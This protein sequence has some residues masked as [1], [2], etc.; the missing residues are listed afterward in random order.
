MLSL[1]ITRQ[2]DQFAAP[3]EPL[4]VPRAMAVHMVSGPWGGCHP[5]MF[6]SA[7]ISSLAL[8]DADISYAAWRARKAT[9]ARLF[10]QHELHSRW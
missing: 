10:A 8:R 3:S 6:P 5:L 9:R 4:H 7:T 1:L 2:V